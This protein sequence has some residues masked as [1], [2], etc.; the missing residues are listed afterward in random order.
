MLC[1][2]ALSPSTPSMPGPQGCEK[3][4]RPIGLVTFCARM[5]FLAVMWL[6]KQTSSNEAVVNIQKAEETQL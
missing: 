6:E 3:L 2:Y 5:I 1:T 4:H